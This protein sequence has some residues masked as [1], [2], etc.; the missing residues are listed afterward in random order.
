MDQLRRMVEW[1]HVDAEWRMVT[2]GHSG[3]TAAAD[4]GKVNVV[5]FL[6]E[7]VRTPYTAL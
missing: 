4:A 1:N 6:I 2:T 3:L 7:E 5:K